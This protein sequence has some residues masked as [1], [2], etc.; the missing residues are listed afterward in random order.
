MINWTI[1]IK[2]FSSSKTPSAVKK[3]I[4]KVAGEIGNSNLFFKKAFRDQ[5]VTN[6]KRLSLYLYA[7]H[8]IASEYIK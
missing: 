4:Y 7:S 6:N 3:I 8:E 1:K 2:N 5:K